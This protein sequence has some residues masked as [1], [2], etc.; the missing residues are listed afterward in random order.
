MHL[1]QPFEN[2]FGDYL[3]YVE[4]YLLTSSSISFKESAKVLL[5]I[6]ED[7][8]L[9]QLLFLVVGIETLVK[10]NTEGQVFHLF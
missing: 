7:Q 8:V 1:P 9:N 3:N 6:L 5:K 2:L 10:M 4:R